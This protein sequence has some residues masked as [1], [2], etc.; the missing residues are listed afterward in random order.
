MPIDLSYYPENWPQLALELKE[1]ANWT[2]E[3]CDRPCRKYGEKPH[4]F[5]LRLLEHKESDRWAS[6]LYV[7]EGDRVVVKYQRFILTVA[8]LDQNPANNDP[9]NLRAYCSVCHLRHDRPYRTGNRYRKRERGG[10]L[11]LGL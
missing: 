3:N 8:H 10:Q 11:N 9:A 7:D 4:R 6:D 1:K 5:E 2:C